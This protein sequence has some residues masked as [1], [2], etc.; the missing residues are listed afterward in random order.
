[1]LASGVVGELAGGKDFPF[2]DRGDVALKWFQ[3]SVRLYEVRWR[4]EGD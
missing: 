2:A 3:E 1:V 4:Q